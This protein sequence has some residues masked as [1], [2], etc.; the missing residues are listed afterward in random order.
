M[1]GRKAASDYL[2]TLQAHRDVGLN[3]DEMNHIL[4]SHKNPYQHLR[5]DDF[6]AFY[7]R[8][9]DALIDIVELATG[10]SVQR[11]QSVETTEIEVAS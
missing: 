10:K 11:D 5:D 6:G 2:N 1:I 7:N 3:N 9:K 8:R 4:A